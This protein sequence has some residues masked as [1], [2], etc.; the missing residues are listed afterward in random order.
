MG[1]SS[2]FTNNLILTL[3]SIPYRWKSYLVGWLVDGF[4]VILPFIDFECILKLFVKQGKHNTIT[5][6]LV[7]QG[8]I[9]K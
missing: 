9:R 6:N 3:K 8:E 7:K 5:L 2:F 4:C 1:C